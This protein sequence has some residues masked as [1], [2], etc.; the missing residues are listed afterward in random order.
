MDR[1]SK[2]RS[3]AW[4]R[5]AH[6]FL[7]HFGCGGNLGAGNGAIYWLRKPIINLLRG[8]GLGDGC[9][10]QLVGQ[11]AKGLAPLSRI[12]HPSRHRIQAIVLIHSV[13]PLIPDAV[14]ASANEIGSGAARDSR[15][16]EFTRSPLRGGRPMILSG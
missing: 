8:V 3:A 2:D 13:S 6:Q 10:P 12:P 15:P 1:S 5:D 14:R 4:M 11:V 16:S 7:H 9:G